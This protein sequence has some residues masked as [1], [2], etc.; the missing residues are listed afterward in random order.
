MA[1]VFAGGKVTVPK[2]LRDLL[3]LKDGDY[4]R[5]TLDE[6]VKSCSKASPSGGS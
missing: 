6:V 3:K 1:R 2:Y 5:L 4:V